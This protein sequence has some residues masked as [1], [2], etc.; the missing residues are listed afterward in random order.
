MEKLYNFIK[1]YYND[2][3]FILLDI[4]SIEI[5][6]SNDTLTDTCKISISK[7][8]TFTTSSL[9]NIQDNEFKLG[10]K[11]EVWLGYDSNGKT[12]KN[13]IYI[14]Y[15]NGFTN[16]TDTF[17]LTFEDDMYLLKNDNRIKVSFPSG[18]TLEQVVNKV[19]KSSLVSKKKIIKL[20]AG[21]IT[22]KN[23]MLPSE[24]LTLLKERFGIYCY[25]KK[26]TLYLGHKYWKSYELDYGI[27]GDNKSKLFQFK[28]PNVNQKPF[29]KVLDISSLVYSIIDPNEY[30]VKG[31]SVYEYKP[32]KYEYPD[33]TK[34]PK[35]I[36]TISLPDTDLPTLKKL[37]KER[38]DNLDK[39][40]FTGSFQI[41]GY[42]FIQHGDIVELTINMSHIKDSPRI[43]TEKY[44]VDEVVTTFDSGGY[45]QSIKIGNQML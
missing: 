40:G 37:V 39:G 44:F 5:N 42:P 45:K 7:L 23:N 27:V 2:S 41:F 25:F 43:I 26:Q 34:D 16:N 29:H 1:F 30:K 4:Q 20:D 9:I 13:N 21:T 18:N 11:V 35:N 15:L 22:I 28:F 8:D 36:I 3:S 14:G 38:W 12:T 17:E 33:N 31:S 24:I 19:I 6:S 10:S 32:I